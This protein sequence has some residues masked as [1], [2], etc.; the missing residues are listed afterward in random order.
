MKMGG[1]RILSTSVYA[2]YL[3]PPPTVCPLLPPTL[4]FRACPISTP[5]CA[6]NLP[7]SSHRPGPHAPALLPPTT[8]LHRQHRQHP[9]WVYPQP[10]P[11]I[12]C[13][14][15]S[16]PQADPVC[17]AE[18]RVPTGPTFER[19]ELPVHVVAHVH[20]PRVERMAARLSLRCVGR[21]S[22]DHFTC[23]SPAARLDLICIIHVP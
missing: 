4:L 10:H 8:H 23:S 16:A 12:R 22:Q 14:R 21:K 19:R 2:R 20:H 6:T 3:E 13:E 9:A 7:T 18:C 5:L 1:G 11:N 15:L 17:T